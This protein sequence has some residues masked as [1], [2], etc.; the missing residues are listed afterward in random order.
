[1]KQ[2][3]LQ[4]PKILKTLRFV[5]STLQRRSENFDVKSHSLY[6]IG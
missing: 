4:K 5:I 3:M 2:R 6:H 1:M